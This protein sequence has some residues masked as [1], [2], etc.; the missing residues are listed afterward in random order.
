MIL[1]CCWFI[2]VALSRNNDD[3][4]PSYQSYRT[5]DTHMRHRVKPD[6]NSQNDFK[7][8]NVRHIEYHWMESFSLYSANSNK[9]D[10]FSRLSIVAQTT[11]RLSSEWISN[12]PGFD[13]ARPFDCANLATAHQRICWV[14]RRRICHGKECGCY[15][16][17]RRRELELQVD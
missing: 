7:K 10:T 6:W 17:V 16:N 14:S 12:P 2:D 4:Y 5:A 1:N 9:P 3:T 11:I 15:G 8:L 13:A